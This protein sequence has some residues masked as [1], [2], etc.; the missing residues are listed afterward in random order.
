M[1]SITLKFIR[2]KVE[3][4]KGF[5]YESV[6]YCPDLPHT[7]HVTVVPRVRSQGRCSGCGRLCSTYDHLNPRTWL[8]PPLW[9]FALALTD[10]VRR[11]H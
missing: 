10:H 3:A 1:D 8:L 6:R 5:V 4:I 7:I 9:Q 11:V 2:N